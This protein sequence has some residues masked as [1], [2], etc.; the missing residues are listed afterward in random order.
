MVTPDNV[1]S[2]KKYHKQQNLS[3]T[4]PHQHHQAP[5]TT[6]SITRNPLSSNS[7]NSSFRLPNLGI[8]KLGLDK[9]LDGKDG[10]EVDG[11]K[12]GLD[13]VLVG[14]LGIEVDGLRG[15]LVGVVVGRVGVVGG[16][17]GDE[18]GRLGIEVDGLS[19]GLYGVVEGRLGIE[20]DG[21]SGGL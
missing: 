19:G 6:L 9:D 12:G 1:A 3:I 18:V 14:R 2:P 10:I 5:P 7:S 21:F 15:G 4:P 8:E 16:F 13:G 11:L 20:V 17:E